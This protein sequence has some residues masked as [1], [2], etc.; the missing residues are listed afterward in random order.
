[1]KETPYIQI[2]YTNLKRKK[3]KKKKKV[4][5]EMVLSWKL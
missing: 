2:Y 3:Q 5:K 4:K 1:M